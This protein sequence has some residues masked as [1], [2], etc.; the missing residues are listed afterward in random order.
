MSW[1][2]RLLFGGET[3]PNRTAT[4]AWAQQRTRP[5]AQHRR[6]TV[7]RPRTT[8][9]SGITRP[10]PASVFDLP[11]RERLLLALVGPLPPNIFWVLASIAGTT[12]VLFGYLDDN[13]I[14]FGVI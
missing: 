9:L 8:S 12:S 1:W 11:H 4:A 6:A 5:E 14:A 10:L 7:A 13:P 2:K 3:H